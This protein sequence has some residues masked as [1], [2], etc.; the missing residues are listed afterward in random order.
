MPGTRFRPLSPE[1]A[2]DRKIR[3]QLLTGFAGVV[4]LQAAGRDHLPHHPGDGAH[5]MLQSSSRKGGVA[6]LRLEWYRR[7]HGGRSPGLAGMGQQSLSRCRMA[8]VRL[9][10]TIRTM[11]ASSGL[12]ARPSTSSGP[13]ASPRAVFA[14]TQ[15]VRL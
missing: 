14:S 7:L 5:N 2:R 15:R 13:A 3:S 4:V 6:V 10:G 12:S 9:A 11:S 1:M 8:C